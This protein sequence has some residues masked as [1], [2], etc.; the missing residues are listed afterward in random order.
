MSLFI[1]VPVRT[2]LYT[3][4]GTQ[5]TEPGRQQT[6]DKSSVTNN[7]SST[8]TTSSSNL[9]KTQRQN[10]RKAEEAKAIRHDAEI[11]RLQKL[12]AYRNERYQQQQQVLVWKKDDPTT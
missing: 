1:T 3:H 10:R 2:R 8:P 6:S 7:S 11:E 5:T 4:K 9:T 12:A